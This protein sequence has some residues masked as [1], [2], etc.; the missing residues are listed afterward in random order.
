MWNRFETIP[1]RYRQRSV[2]DVMLMA[3]SQP[4]I[5][6]W[7]KTTHTTF[8][9]RAEVTSHVRSNWKNNFEVKRSKI[10]VTVGRKGRLH[11]A[12]AIGTALACFTVKAE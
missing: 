3:Y 7:L 8:I 2:T 12:S 11:I 4:S 10:K 5:D 6:G 9:L 1:E